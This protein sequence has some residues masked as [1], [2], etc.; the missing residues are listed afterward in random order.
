MD[1]FSLLAWKK[2][3]KKEQKEKREDM[4]RFQWKGIPDVEADE[5]RSPPSLEIEQENSGRDAASEMRV[6]VNGGKSLQRRAEE[7]VLNASSNKAQPRSPAPPHSAADDRVSHAGDQPPRPESGI[8]TKGASS[9]GFQYTGRN[10]PNLPTDLFLERITAPRYA[11]R[12]RSESRRVRSPTLM[13]LGRLVE[14]DDLKSVLFE[15]SLML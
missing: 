11:S 9:K 4:G 15:R 12:S 7:M 1:V 13:A 10:L 6:H 2:K 5:S 14:D 8:H 3:E